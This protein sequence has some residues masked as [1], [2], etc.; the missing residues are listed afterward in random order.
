MSEEFLPHIYEEFSREK[1]TTDN[2]IEGTGLGMPIVKRLVDIMGGTIE[3]KSEKGKGSSFTV[4]IPHRIADKSDLVD[5]S[6][7]ELDYKAFVGKRILLAEDN[8]LNAEIAI[9]ILTEAGFTVDRAEDGQICVEMLNK[10]ADN[11]YD[12]I[13]M[14]IQMPHM[15]GY[16]AT[17]T[18]RL[19]DNPVKANIPIIAMTANAFEE[20]K[21][22]AYHSG[23]NGHLAKPINVR[24]LMRMLMRIL[25]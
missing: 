21:R 14:D 13:L 6:V 18:I 15:N 4:T 2:K 3:V 1:S 24:E 12:V 20:D 19:L 10:A 11:F 25:K 16:E 9:D 8:D 22:E 23:M 5:H 7:V 17:R